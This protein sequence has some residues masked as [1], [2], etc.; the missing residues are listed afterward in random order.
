MLICGDNV[1]EVMVEILSVVVGNRGDLFYHMKSA[2]ILV[3]VVSALMTFISDR[4]DDK[5]Y[6]PNL[7]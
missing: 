6:L 2:T 3:V 4:G 1:L 7:L 5:C